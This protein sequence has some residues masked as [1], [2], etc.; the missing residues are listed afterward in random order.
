MKVCRRCP[1][2]TWWF[3]VRGPTY[4]GLQEMPYLDMVVSGE[5]TDVLILQEMYYLDMVVS[6][7]GTHI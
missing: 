3:Q 7:E 2:S 6:C 5:G 4:E 1:T